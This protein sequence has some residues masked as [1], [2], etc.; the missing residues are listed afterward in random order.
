MTDSPHDDSVEQAGATRRSVI[1]TLGGAA[2]GV[3]ALGFAA[4]QAG[5]SQAA[6]EDRG[7]TPRA[8]A[9]LDAACVLTPEQT[10]GPYYLDLETVRKN[11]TEGKAG[12]PLT[13]RVTVVDVAT[14]FPLPNTAVDIWHCDALGVYSGYV[15]G[16]STPDTTF[17]RGVQLTD[18]T[19]VAEFTTVYPGW[20]VGRALHIHIKTH[21]GGTVSNGTYH[22][23]HVS[24]T[25]Q[26]YFPE[27][28]NTRIAALTP[29]R[30]NTATRT[31]NAR[32]GIYR[33]G[34]S[35]TLLTVTQ[36]GSDLGKGVTGTV[37]LGVDPAAT[38]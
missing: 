3:T 25:G 17:L 19:G 15:A 2:L 24:H 37:V 14:C 16:G 32:D 22:G 36:V 21:T 1:A 33:N 12:V 11:I 27:T 6:A 31:L 28:Y 10:E 8:A 35:S 5:A 18:S 20:Y 38:P 30:G 26:L 13:L 4:S 7:S 9:E 34:G 29:Y 23:G